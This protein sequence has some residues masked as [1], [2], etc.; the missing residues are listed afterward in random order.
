MVQSGYCS[1][2]IVPFVHMNLIVCNVE[3]SL[4]P[5][6][7]CGGRP[8]GLRDAEDPTLS[9]QLT[10][11]SVLRSTLLPRNII[12][13]LLLHISVRGWVNLRAKFDW[14]DYGNWKYLMISSGL[15]LVVI[16]HVYISYMKK[17]GFWDHHVVSDY[18]WGLWRHCVCACMCRYSNRA[19]R[20]K[21]Q[22]KMYL[23]P[24]SGHTD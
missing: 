21:H 22:Q 13:L 10:V 8:I 5:V 4:A 7:G 11:R 3:L 12:F 6:T 20:I 18:L 16:V 23:V 24:V 2:T 19:T 15:R 9:T 14:K 17:K 1:L